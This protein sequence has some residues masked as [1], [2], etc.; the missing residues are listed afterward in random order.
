[1]L[2]AEGEAAAMEMRSKAQA[3][4]IRQVAEA[5]AGAH[6][7]EAAK[8]AVAREVS[9][10]QFFLYLSSV[11]LLLLDM[12]STLQCTRILVRRVTQ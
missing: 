3:A 7:G 8:L 11:Y 12:L 10:R 2:Q 6:A 9:K 5:L 4:A 1:M